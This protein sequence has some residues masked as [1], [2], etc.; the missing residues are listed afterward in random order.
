[1]AN[2]KSK[3]N[4]TKLQRNSFMAEVLKVFTTNSQKSYN[5]RQISSLLGVNDKASKE[6]VR[7]ML[8]ELKQVNAIN[9]ISRGKFKLNEDLAESYGPKATVVTGKVDMKSTGKAYV[10]CKDMDEDVFIAANNTGTAFHGDTVQV[11]LFPQRKNRKLEGKII[12]IVKRDRTQFVGVFKKSPKFAFVIPDG[13][14]MPVDF[15]IPLEDSMKA[16]DG[17]KVVVELAEWPDKAKNPV[18]KVVEILG[19]PGDNNVEMLSI[20]VNNAFP[21]HFPSNVEKE[22]EKIPHTISESE[23]SKRR[24]FRN[25]LTFTIDPADAKDFD[26]ALSLQYLPDGDYEVGIHIADVSHYVHPSTLIDNEAFDRGTSVYLVDRTIPML[27]EAL[28]N[29]LCSLQ[30][31]KDRLC[32][33]AVFVLDEE[34]KVK[35]QWFGKTVIHSDRR[36]DYEEAQA[37]IEGKQDEY[38]KVMLTLDRLAKKLRDERYKKGSIDFGS[39]EVKF[40]LDET[41]KPIEVYFKESKDS[42]KLIED[43]M[44]LANRKVAERIQTFKKNPKDE[45]KPFVYRIHDKPNEAKLMQFSDFIG[46]MGYKL[47]L[48]NHKTISASL[49]K[50]FTDIS[51]K[52]EQNMIETIAVRTMAKA[53][54][55]TRNIG[56]YG[57]AFDFYTHFT[58]P[59]RRY[60][61]LMVHRL[62]FNYINNK[63]YVVDGEEL[64]EK[65][66][67]CSE[68]ERRAADAERDS[69]KLKQMEFMAEHIG[70]TFH[71]LIS[72][73][74]KWG[75]FVE[76]DISKAEGLVR[77][78]DMK[79]DFYYLD[80]E[81]YQVVGHHHGKVYKLSDPIDVVVKSIDLQ[82]KQM[83]LAIAE[84]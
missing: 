82:K 63:N 15:F 58:S 73:V 79:D 77:I 26:D 5:F 48:S 57:L 44:L 83:D 76:L 25:I 43:F 69:V 16:K 9:E 33:S 54:Y 60:P 14:N 17:E 10:I 50:L 28:S 30:P 52:G 4:I 41:G 19:Q 81:N 3:P 71:G 40:K 55:S 8:Y 12:K 61:D 2:K 70:K 74:S 1:M 6:L 67:H 84:K 53:I 68:M 51:G 20:L 59:I 45:S 62:L 13:D 39:E 56:H 34:A 27:P 23:I 36:F 7:T 42:N 38:S 29:E 24:D 46:K 22:A 47:N 18:A 35:N 65:C 21:A 78:E 49:N 80:E 32:F 72:G 75:L 66:I 31:N 64:E 37:I 11:R